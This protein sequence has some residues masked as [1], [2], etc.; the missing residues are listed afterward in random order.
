MPDYSVLLLNHH[1][2]KGKRSLQLPQRQWLGGRGYFTEWNGKQ[3]TAMQVLT[4]VSIL[5]KLYITG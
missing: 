4:A 2:K 3:G 1:A 5:H